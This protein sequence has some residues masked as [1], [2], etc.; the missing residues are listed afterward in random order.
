MEEEGKR[1]RDY[2]AGG[3]FLGGLNEEDEED[4]EQH[5]LEEARRKHGDLV[6]RTIDQHRARAAANAAAGIKEP[7]TTQYVGRGGAN[8]REAEAVLYEGR[9]GQRDRG[10]AKRQPFELNMGNA[11]LLERRQ[12]R[13]G[14][15]GPVSA[16][17]QAPAVIAGT[18]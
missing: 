6:A 15:G 14:V 12:K 17:H 3:G 13:G 2:A 4:D 18:G 5:Q 8:R 9:A 11:T 10:G 7:T 16:A 1:R